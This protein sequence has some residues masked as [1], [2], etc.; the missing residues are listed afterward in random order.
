MRPVFLVLN[1][2]SSSIKFQLFDAGGAGEPRRVYRGLFEGLGGSPHFR[3]PRRRGQVR[4]RSAWGETE[5]FGHEEALTHLGR[6]DRRAS[7][8]PPCRPLATGSC[9][10]G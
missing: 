10:A 1:A 2:G 5:R 9:T 7:G 8:E 4:R 3:G 6:L